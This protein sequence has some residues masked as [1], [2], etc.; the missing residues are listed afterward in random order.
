MRCRLTFAAG[1]FTG[2]LLLTYWI[3]QAAVDAVPAL[4][5]VGPTADGGWI[6][7]TGHKVRS[8]GEPIAFPGR[9]VALALSKDGSVL[10]V[11]DNMGIR[12]VGTG[13]FKIRQELPFPKKDGAS[14]H[15]LALSHDGKRLYATTAQRHLH[16]AAID[17]RGDLKWNRAIWLP[18]PKILETSHSLGIALTKDG[19]KAF[20]CL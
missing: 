15:G 7:P 10:Y 4:E 8:A 3:V 13:D 14:M 20:I 11:K 9:P 5:G 19:N 18:G 17:A 6:M 16:E 2:L 1:M 12:V